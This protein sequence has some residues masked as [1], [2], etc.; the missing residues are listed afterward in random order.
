MLGIDFP[1]SHAG[2]HGAGQ[3][4]P[5]VASVRRVEVL[6]AVV[7]DQD[8][9]RG[10]RRVSDHQQN[11]VR[12]G[13]QCR[14][15]GVEATPQRDRLIQH[16]LRRRAPFVDAALRAFGDMP[17]AAVT[18]PR[19]V[20]VGQFLPAAFAVQ[21]ER[22][23]EQCGLQLDEAR[24]AGHHLA[25][26]AVVEQRTEGDQRVAEGV[27]ARERL[28]RRPRATVRRAQHQQAGA[29]PR[30]Q[31]LPGVGR[32]Q[33][34]GARHQ[35]AHRMGQ[36]PHRLAAGA[37]HGQRGV[38]GKRQAARLVFDRPAPVVGEWNHLV[39]VGQPLDQV[40]IA[41]ADRAIGLEAAGAV[42][43]PGQFFQA[44]DEA[45]AEPDALAIELDVRAED[46][47]QDEHSRPV[48]GSGSGA[49]RTAARAGHRPRC[50]RAAG[51]LAGPGQRADGLKASGRGIEQ[52]AR[53]R[54]YR[55]LVGEVVE[56]RDLA[57]PIQQEAGTGAAGPVRGPIARGRGARRPAVHR[58]GLHH[59]VVVGPV[60]GVGQQGLD[61]GADRVALQVAG[62][63]TQV[64]RQR[65]LAAV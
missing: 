16:G 13:A 11:L 15:L 54:A 46:A 4:D 60:E 12:I 36:Q 17:D 7:V 5:A 10:E 21:A 43:I 58:A 57:A 33:P 41:V 59:Q 47:G 55:A 30:H 50:A 63:H 45:E 9:G 37:A 3:R 29:V 20:V 49:G 65:S 35:A 23:V 22:G 27:V 28:H 39:A 56:V 8:P 24:H 34:H 32:L 25:C 44:V 64:A 18:Q 62:D 19:H 38:H 2:Q 14:H 53:D 52:R 6:Q 61:P 1:G 42:G 26:T 51:V 48:C 31:P 40:V